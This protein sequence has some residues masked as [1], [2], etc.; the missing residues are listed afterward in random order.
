VVVRIEVVDEGEG[1]AGGLGDG[2]DALPEGVDVDAGG[3]VGGEG[4]EAGGGVGERG[5]GP[6]LHVA[7]PPREPRAPRPPHPAHL[8]RRL[9]Q[10]LL[11][12]PQ[13]VRA[14]PHRAAPAAAAGALGRAGGAAAPEVAR[15]GA[16]AVGADGER[17]LRQETRAAPHRGGL[18]HEAPLAHLRVPRRAARPPHEVRRRGRAHRRPGPGGL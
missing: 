8:R 2:A 3:G 4:V 17:G 15:A 11:R 7:Q 14:V 1:V 12:V 13:R 6:G 9:P 5:A 10:P 18:R 16:R